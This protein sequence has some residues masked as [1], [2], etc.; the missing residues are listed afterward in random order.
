M[1]ERA[2]HEQAD[3]GAGGADAEERG[4]RVRLL[5]GL[6][7]DLKNPLGAVDGY[8]QLLQE[9]LKGELNEGQHALVR[10]LRAA[11]AAG[12]RIVEQLSELAA[13]EAGTAEVRPVAVDAGRIIEQAVERHSEAAAR[14]E[15]RLDAEMPSSSAPFTTDA[16]R[17]RAIVDALLAHGL[18]HASPGE[19]VRVEARVESPAGGGSP[20]LVVAVRD[21]GPA[22]G[23][24]DAELV[25]SAFSRLEPDLPRGSG[26][27]LALARANARLLGGDVEL[28]PGQE[29]E[30]VCLRAWIPAVRPR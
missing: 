9:G 30:G 1:G 22:V 21:A 16:D 20:A 14:A 27:E 10:K 2:R 7:H 5:R 15:L 25:F 18:A 19:A 8:A 12:L 6:S 23:G 3:A 17:L 24:D 4:A 26:I 29:G 11:V 28:I 13:L